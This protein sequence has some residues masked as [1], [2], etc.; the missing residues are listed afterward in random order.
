[1]LKVNP[2]K[3]ASG[4]AQVGIDGHGVLVRFARLGKPFL[5]EKEIAHQ[6]VKRRKL[7]LELQCSL[8]HLNRVADLPLRLIHPA[9][10]QVSRYQGR[11]D[12][13][14]ALQL[15][16]RRA[17][18]FHRQIN[19]AENQVSGGILR[20]INGVL[21]HAAQGLGD[22]VTCCPEIYQLPQSFRIVWIHAK[23]AL[24]LLFCLSPLA[25]RSSSA[26]QRKR[27]LRISG[28]QLLSNKKLFLRFIYLAHAKV[29]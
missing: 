29:D 15:G 10:L 20:L 19:G 8:V 27:H 2:R 7:R 26:R 3:I 25:I 23:S 4:Y 14:C 5:I 24:K 9:Q 13:D 16:L 21:L 22:L 18:I 1:M 6:H 11:I 28:R 17:V 12:S